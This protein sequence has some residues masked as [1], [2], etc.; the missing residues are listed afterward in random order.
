[1]EHEGPL[2]RTDPAVRQ[3]R[4]QDPQ[5]VLSKVRDVRHLEDKGRVRRGG[6]KCFLERARRPTSAVPPLDR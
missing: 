6:G 1:M 2:V 3:P 4:T 5:I